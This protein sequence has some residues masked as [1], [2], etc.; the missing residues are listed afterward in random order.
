[1]QRT[2]TRG[3]HFLCLVE[4]LLSV[5]CS[6]PVSSFGSLA[7][8]RTLALSTQRVSCIFLW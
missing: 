3:L 5:I 6:R 7:A 4:I 1:M 8:E 2:K